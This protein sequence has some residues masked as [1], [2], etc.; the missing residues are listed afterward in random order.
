V[1]ADVVAEDLEDQ[2]GEAVHDVGRLR[3]A[4]IGVHHAV[5]DKPRRHPIEIADCLPE[6]GQHRD[7]CTA[8]GGLSVLH[9]DLAGDLP[10]GAQRLAGRAKRPM[11]RQ[12]GAIA[13]DPSP[14]EG[15]RE[16]GG[17]GGGWRELEPKFG[18]P[19]LDM[20]HAPSSLIDSLSS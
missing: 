8:S 5:H 17:C 2:V 15:E 11:S 19:V 6:A 10:E 12:E 7:G 13:V 1:V 4:E 16:P 18:Q 3:V 14:R 9:R 20:C